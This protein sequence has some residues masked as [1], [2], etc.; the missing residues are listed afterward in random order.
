M[1]WV[2]WRRLAVPLRK[3]LPSLRSRVMSALPPAGQEARALGEVG[4]GLERVDEARD[5][6]RVGGA[7]GV[8]HDDEV[9]GDGGEAGAEGVALAAAAL[10]EDADV[11]IGVA[12]G[13]DRVVL[14]VAVDEDHLVQ[15]LGQLRRARG[16][17]S[18]LVHRRDDDAD[19]GPAV[20]RR[21]GPA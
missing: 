13:L 1:K 9:A 10:G 2:P 21:S 14:G 8:E 12:G 15:V 7:V 4:A 16:R 3:V 18:R 6:G 19:L 17:C 5:L 11:G 20:A